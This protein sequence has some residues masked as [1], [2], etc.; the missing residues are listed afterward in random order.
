MKAAGFS[1]TPGSG[2]AGAAKS[3]SPAGDADK[4]ATRLNLAKSLLVAGKNP[5]LAEIERNYKLRVY[6]VSTAA[7]ALGE[8]LPG[9]D[10]AVRKLEPTGQSSR[11][12][13]ALHSVLG[14]LRGTPP[15]AIVLVSDGVS[16]DGE[17]LADAAKSV[18]RKGTPLFTVGLGNERPVRD[19]EVSDLLV[20]EVVFVDDIVNFE[21][22]LTGSGLTGRNVDIVL[23]EKDHPRVLARLKAVV[24]A[25]GKPQ[26]LQLPYR[27]TETGEFEYVVEALPVADEIQSENN[28]QTRVV[29]VRKERIRALFAQAYPNNEFRYLKHMLERDGTVQLRTVLQDADVEYAELDQSALPIF[30]VRRD[31]LFEYDCVLLGDVNPALLSTSALANLAA[32][33]EE[34][35]GGVAFIA[36]PLHM[37]LAYRGTPLEPLFPVELGAATAPPEGQAI[38]EGFVPLPTDM[39]LASPQMQLGDNLVETT[40]HLARSAA[41][42]LVA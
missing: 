29:S 4:T 11:L 35:G 9:V 18:R 42:V 27:P 2:R 3:S 24:G 10:E 23:R 1:D 37:P 8:R 13:A 40:A 20:D 30:P 28:R 31:E 33:V 19:L 36:G 22:K 16:T 14:D 26:R 34:K 6:A 5:I 41:L 7:R 17:S 32:F 15:A 25:D 39:G 38:T 21:F 12:G